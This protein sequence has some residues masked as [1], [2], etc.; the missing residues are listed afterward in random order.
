MK[1][2]SFSSWVVA[3]S[4]AGSIFGILSA[5]KVYAQSEDEVKKLAERITGVKLP[6]DSPLL[7]Q[8]RVLWNQGNRKAAAQLAI[9]DPRFIN[10]TTKLMAL[11][12]STRAETMRTELNDFVATYMGVVRDD[13][14]ARQLLMGD[15]HYRGDM[16]K[17][18]NGSLNVL[19]DI[20]LSNNHY[21]S[22]DK[23]NIDLKSVLV[24][25]AKQPMA[26]EA[27]GAPVLMDNPDPAGLLTT[28]A[29]LSAH[30]VAGT[31]RRPVEYTMREFMCVAMADWSDVG[32]SDARVGR[33][34]DRAPG[35]DPQ[36]FLTSCK[37]CHTGMDGFRL[38]FSKNDFQTSNAYP[39]GRVINSLMES[40]TFPG[41]A[42]G[43][44]TST[45]MDKAP[46]NLVFP[47]GYVPVDTNW[48][49]NARGPSNSQLFGWR[50]NVAG[51]AG[52]KSFA[53][54]IANS[55]RF[56]LCMV[57]RVYEGICR[58]P[59]SISANK[60]AADAMA[61]VLENNNYSIK[62]LAMEVALSRECGL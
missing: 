49:N 54:A 42:A 18:P 13:L 51:G 6:G 59:F 22:L 20:V 29:F 27:G 19:A 41:F 10:V 61:A 35:G 34:V 9:N 40:A 21:I 39:Q 1:P 60:S 2:Y 24:R 31:N 15:F 53:E 48:V 3:A 33:D 8:M 57:Q 28:R 56:S 43:T 5:P 55:K 50:G 23:P 11:K 36:K 14:D 45:K 46:N 44:R 30:A 4:I 12:M 7:A 25:V 32:A 26:S 16:A 37:G 47:N 38:A 58:R 62:N 52:V 17:V